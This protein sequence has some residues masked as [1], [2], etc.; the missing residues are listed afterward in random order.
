MNLSVVMITKNAD[1]VIE[2][3][4]KSVEGLWDE[5]LIADDESTDDTRMLIKQYEGKIVTL[6]NK[7]LGERKQWLVEHAKKEWVLVL[8]SDE[9][10]SKELY[11]E[12]KRL[13]MS[14]NDRKINGYW[15]PYQNYI[16]G[17]P[18]YWGGEKYSK[19][20]FFRKGKGN[21]DPFPVHEEIQVNGKVA[22]LKGVI[23][24]HSYRSFDQLF[25]KFTGYAWIAA[26]K[27]H[28][29]KEK[30][31]L[32]K[33]FCYAPHMFWAR[34]VKEKGYKDRW[35]GFILAFAFAYMEGLTYW[36][37]FFKHI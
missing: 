26:Q 17:K 28:D 3:A 23:H 22:Q 30:I 19:V 9:K 35:R 6:K 24:H 25:L 27:K 20:R 36:I 12:I 13:L 18:I 37:L 33:L 7:N 29:E 32:E 16:F 1:E 31:S 21:V 11:K 2:E 5:L 15:I 34:F 8:D 4:L 14:G 10:V